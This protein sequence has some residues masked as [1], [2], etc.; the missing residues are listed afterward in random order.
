VVILVVFIDAGVSLDVSG[1]AEALATIIAGGATN[2]G[3]T[4]V[5]VRV[6]EALGKSAGAEDTRRR[7]SRTRVAAMGVRIDRSRVDIGVLDLGGVVI[8]VLLFGLGVEVSVHRHI[9]AL[10]L[11][12]ARGAA[13]DSSSMGGITLSVEGSHS[14]DL[15]AV[16]KGHTDHMTVRVNIRVCQLDRVVILLPL[17]DLGIGLDISRVGADEAVSMIARRPSDDGRTS[18]GMEVTMT[19]TIIARR[20]SDDGTTRLGVEVI[21]LLYPK[22]AD[23]SL[24][25][26]EDGIHVQRTSPGQQL[27]AVPQGCRR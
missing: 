23:V 2:D 3:S 22:L 5:A 25:S 24:Y 11:I 17:V 9:E 8:L 15:G 7:A 20:P 13:H 14:R 10:T 27:P 16:A 19:M 6:P 18:L 26:E 1:S 21:L 12:V 4:G